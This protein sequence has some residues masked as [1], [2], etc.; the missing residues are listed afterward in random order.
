[1]KLPDNKLILHEWVPAERDIPFYPWE[2]IIEFAPQG[3]Y[4]GGNGWTKTDV[5]EIDGQTEWGCIQPA[6]LHHSGEKYQILCRPGTATL[7]VYYSSFTTNNGD[8]RSAVTPI[9]VHNPAA[10][11]CP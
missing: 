8:S 9:G 4:D 11:N 6:F 7:P 1:M 3:R 2:I 10:P 5:L